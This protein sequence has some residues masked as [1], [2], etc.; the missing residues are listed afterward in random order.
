MESSELDAKYFCFRA[1]KR[2]E[3]NDYKRAI[4]DFTRALR[5]NPENKE[6]YL[7]RAK[8][9]VKCELYVK[10]IEDCTLYIK[11]NP[12]SIEAFLI[13]GDCYQKLHNI[14]LALKDFQKASSFGSMVASGKVK[15]IEIQLQKINT[16]IE[17]YSKEINDQPLNPSFY[18]GRA[19]TYKNIENNKVHNFQ[20]AIK[21]LCKCIDLDPSFE[22]AYV[23]LVKLKEFME[24][25]YENKFYDSEIILCIKKYESMKNLRLVA[26]W[27]KHQEEIA[28]EFDKRILNNPLIKEKLFYVIENLKDQYSEEQI[29]IAAGYFKKYENNKTFNKEDFQKA[30]LIAEQSF[31]KNKLYEFKWNNPYLYSL[32]IFNNR[33]CS[34]TGSHGYTAFVSVRQ[35]KASKEFDYSNSD[36]KDWNIETLVADVCCTASDEQEAKEL[37]D[38]YSFKEPMKYVDLEEWFYF[39]EN[40]E[41]Q[42]DL[43]FSDDE[44]G[45]YYGILYDDCIIEHR[46]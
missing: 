14:E 17:Q 31:D 42:D 27:K 5:I 18:F 39:N 10:A 13:R 21:D 29:G 36:L 11:N 19:I 35:I 8:A 33:F 9:K 37:I 24:I 4:N 1:Q 20:L 3:K 16:K 40:L 15:S 32:Q 2:V 22:E 38:L 45:E 7:L 28:E 30:K 41:Y 23:E 43:A 44:I 25:Y 6:I 34:F 26:E 12:E 46:Y